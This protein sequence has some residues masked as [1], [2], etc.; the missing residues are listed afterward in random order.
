[1]ERQRSSQPSCRLSFSNRGSSDKTVSQL[2]YRPAQ[3]ACGPCQVDMAPDRLEVRIHKSGDLRARSD[4]VLY[5]FFM[6]KASPHSAHGDS[7]DTVMAMALCDRLHLSVGENGM[8][9][10][11]VSVLDH[12]SVVLGQGIIGWS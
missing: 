10:R 8:V 7:I 2:R 11:S 6:D 12:R 5:S 9:G 1:M 3:G 4:S